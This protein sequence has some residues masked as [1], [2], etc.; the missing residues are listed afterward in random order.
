M[1]IATWNVNGI[2][3]REAQLCDWV[4]RDR[5]DVICLQELKADP[6][7]IPE[8]CKLADYHVYWHG[9]RGYSGVS[10][11]LRKELFDAEPVFSHP[12]FDMESR[13]V[14]VALGNL[15]LASVYVPNGGKDYAA[16][17]NFLRRLA[18]WTKA[19][20][21]EGR[22]VVLCGDINIAR[23][24]MDVHPRERKAGVIGQR[25]EERELFEGLLGGH[26]VDV[27]RALDPE[28]A[29]MFTW[30]PPWRNMRQRNIG[31]RIDYIL[32]SRTIASRAT[33]C[34]VLA[35]VGTSDH[36]PVLMTIA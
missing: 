22:E 20:H 36:A 21:Q 2:R 10:L 5:P 30:W 35:D 8:R 34:V 18:A 26:S 16:K 23:S 25:I 11:H 19:L 33:S 12:E 28:N 1:K 29:S 4:G 32:A 3:A 24:D 17:L 31:W 27:G 15:V 7:Q 6:A 9:L 14:Q 13:I